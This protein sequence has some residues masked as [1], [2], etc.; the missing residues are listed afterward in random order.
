LTGRM[1]VPQ[2][3][4]AS[5]CPASRLRRSALA[6]LKQRVTVR[7]RLAGMHRQAHDL[8]PGFQ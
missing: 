8:L 3:V 2:S 1:P 7:P 4:Q 6:G 5:R